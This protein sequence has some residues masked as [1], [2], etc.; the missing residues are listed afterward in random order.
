MNHYLIIGRIIGDDEDT[1][2]QIEAVNADEAHKEYVHQMLEMDGGGD[3][4]NVVVNHMFLCPGKL[5]IDYSRE[6]VA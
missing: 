6:M 3:A 4:D 5:S 1:P 2:I